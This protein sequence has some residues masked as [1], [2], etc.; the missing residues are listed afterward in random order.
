MRKLAL[1]FAL[2]AVSLVSFAQK[3]MFMIKWD[4]M[5]GG[6]YGSRVEY[7]I[8]SEYFVTTLVSMSGGGYN[9]SRNGSSIWVKYFIGDKDKTP[10]WFETHMDFLNYIGERGYKLVSKE[11]INKYNTS[12]TFVKK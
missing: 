12:Y 7:E 9:C 8:N 10:M 6:D 3:P 1:T 5:G 2:L 11:N 4:G